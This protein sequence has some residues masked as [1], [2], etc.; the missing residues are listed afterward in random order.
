MRNWKEIIRSFEESGQSIKMYCEQAS[1][2]ES[3]FRYHL[4][5]HTSVPQG[6][7]IKVKASINTSQLEFIY[8]NGVRVLVHGEINP[9]I[10][11][12]LVYV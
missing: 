10:L 9:V 8:P 6:G 5:K 7:F 11:S 4:K 2:K 1:I 3:T 12:T